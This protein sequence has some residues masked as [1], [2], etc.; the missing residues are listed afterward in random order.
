[1]SIFHGKQGPDMER[2]TSTPGGADGLNG[3]A[4]SARIV[5][6]SRDFPGGDTNWEQLARYA[7]P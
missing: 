6:A 4:G 7:S 1:M 3:A 5:V 2:S